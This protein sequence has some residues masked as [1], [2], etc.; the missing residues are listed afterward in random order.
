MSRMGKRSKSHKGLSPQ[1]LDPSV[2]SSGNV[3]R[4]RG[5][6]ENRNAQAGGS[7]EAYFAN[8]LRNKPDQTVD[9]TVKEELHKLKR[10]FTMRKTANTIAEALEQVQKNRLR[11]A[12]MDLSNQAR[13]NNKIPF[14]FRMT[15]K[16]R[17]ER[18]SSQDY[19]FDGAMHSVVDLRQFTKACRMHSADRSLQRHLHNPIDVDYATGKRMVRTSRRN[20]STARPSLSTATATPTAA[21]A[22]TNSLAT[23]TRSHTRLDLK[24]EDKKDSPTPDGLDGSP[25]LFRTTLSLQKSTNLLRSPTLTALQVSTSSGMGSAARA[26]ASSSSPVKR[27]S[28]RARTF[29]HLKPALQRQKS[30]DFRRMP[31]KVG[32]V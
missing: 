23:L 5:L 25:I 18:M 21:S 9:P 26:H 24:T 22:S 15:P 16:D 12:R 10:T 20:N 7:A 11:L 14:S 29:T 4:K 28:K 30:A 27:K 31:V 8:T 19:I 13:D 1:K 2:S 32:I 3:F 17:N 6:N